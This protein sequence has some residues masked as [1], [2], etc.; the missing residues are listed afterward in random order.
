[1]KIS[2]EQTIFEM[3][4]EN[5]GASILDSG[6]AYG[7]NWQRNQAI[8][9]DDF[10]NQATAWLE[11]DIYGDDNVCLSP[12]VSVFHACVNALELDAYCHDYNS[13][14]TGNFNGDYYGTDNDNC[15]WLEENNFTPVG[16]GFNTYNW[17][18]NH[19]QVM[20]GQELERDGG[21]YVLLQIH[22]G[23]DVRGGYTAAKLFRLSGYGDL[24]SLLVDDCGF[25]VSID[26]EYLS[27]T[28][29]GEW[30]TGD[31]SPADDDYLLKFA[32]ACEGQRVIDGEFY[33]YN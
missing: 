6:S 3:L 19:S 28:W 26:D 32:K 7:R 29:H 23:C 24:M 1:M 9:L 18:S 14:G 31:G 30:T 10:R 15:I 20:Q 27:L 8:T 33:A 5:T 22:G 12:T 17:S 25:S 4:T 2:T 11:V 16:D 13:Q 21:K